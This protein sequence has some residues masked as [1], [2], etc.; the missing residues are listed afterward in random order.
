MSNKVARVTLGVVSMAWRSRQAAA[1]IVMVGRNADERQVGGTACSRHLVTRRLRYVEG[2]FLDG[3][4][5]SP[6]GF[7]RE[8]SCPNTWRNRKN[9]TASTG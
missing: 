6:L 5:E 4:T 3:T 2:L 1:G 9:K 7:Q 8:S